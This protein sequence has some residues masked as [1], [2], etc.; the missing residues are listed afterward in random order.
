MTEEILHRNLCRYI[1]RKYPEVM[2]LTDLSG[3]KL[4][5]VLAAKVAK[6]RSSNGYPDL[7]I[8]EPRGKYYGLFL[9][10]KADEAKL[11]KQNGEL[12][13]NAHHKEQS[14][15]IEELKERGYFATFAQGL[16]ASRR[17]IDNYLGN[18][19][20]ILYA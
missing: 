20:Y 16:T 2:F 11:F 17:I 7:M 8:F 19:H 13:A 4:P 1:A 18:S 10:L 6:L 12:Y 5:P 14:E 3:V 15:I 9:E